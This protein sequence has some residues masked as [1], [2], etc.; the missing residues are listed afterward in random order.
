MKEEVIQELKLLFSNKAA[1][2]K[3]NSLQLSFFKD[4]IN[5]FLIIKGKIE[6]GK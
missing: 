1:V 2:G 6:Y 3:P 4:C 5:K